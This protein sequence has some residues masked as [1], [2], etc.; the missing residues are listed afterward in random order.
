MKT[1]SSSLGRLPWLVGFTILALGAGTAWSATSIQ[2]FSAATNDR[3]ANDPSFVGA[4]YDF[5][6]VGRDALGH[7][8][9]MLSPTVFLSA[10]HHQPV[11]SLIFYPGNDPAAT[12]ETV[13]I[14]EGQRIGGTDLYIGRLDSPVSAAIKTYSFVTI[15]PGSINTLSNA[16]VFMNGISPTTAGYGSGSPDVTDQTVGTNLIEGFQSELTVGSAVGDAIFTIRNLAGDG[17]YGYGV[18]THEAQLAVGD[19]GSPLFALSGG[20]LVVAGI[21][22]A[23]GTLNLA[24]GPREFSAYTYTGSY[25][26]AIEDYIEVAAVPEP[27]S[28]LLISASAMLLGL[29]RRK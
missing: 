22:W 24:I 26:G 25:T 8:A 4:A 19:S 29:R 13:M 27:S 3:F 16:Y 2:S 28:L 23:V 17:I 1:S 5:S 9:V 12:P 10:H 21:S 20:N 15:P 14:D 11:G 18:T 7:W 6:G